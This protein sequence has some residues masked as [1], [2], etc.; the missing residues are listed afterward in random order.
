[1]QIHI[2]EASTTSKYI[3]LL[4]PLL[5]RLPTSL[6]APSPRSTGHSVGTHPQHYHQHRGPPSLQAPLPIILKM[7][8]LNII[9]AVLFALIAS[10]FAIPVTD[11][12][13]TGLGT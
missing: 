13:S 6:A 12:T 1:M 11:M 4:F 5:D 7:H 8:L 3:L 2:S 9:M 10:A